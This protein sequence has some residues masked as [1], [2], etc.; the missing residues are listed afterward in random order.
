MYR[1]TEKR[2]W[3]M[4]KNIGKRGLELGLSIQS[5]LGHPYRYRVLNK[6]GSS[7]FS[8]YRMTARETYHFLE[9]IIKTLDHLKYSN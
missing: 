6:D 7:Y 1:I 9:G 5:N 2:L 8:S 3:N 4:I